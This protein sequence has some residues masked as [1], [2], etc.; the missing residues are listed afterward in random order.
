[1]TE[2]DFTPEE[3]AGLESSSKE[4]L[5]VGASLADMAMTLAPNGLGAM[6]SL[7]VALNLV[8]QFLFKEASIEM[9]REV[10]KKFIDQVLVPTFDTVLTVTSKPKGNA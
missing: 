4:A 6:T 1:M 3:L 9:Q 5:P 7:A 2:F 8:I 10:H